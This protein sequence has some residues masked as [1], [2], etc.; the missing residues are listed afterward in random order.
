[1]TLYCTNSIIVIMLA[2]YVDNF[3]RLKATYNQ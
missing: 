3:V 2:Y 1:M